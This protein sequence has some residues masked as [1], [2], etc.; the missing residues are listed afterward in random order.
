MSLQEP[1]VWFLFLPI[2]WIGGVIA[3]SIFY[4]RVH[5]KPI[6]PRIPKSVRFAQRMASGWNDENWFRRLGGAN[7][8]LMVAV[9]D[10]ELTV[11]PFFPFNLMFLPEMWGLE[12][13]VPLSRIR[14]V[15]PT[16]RFFTSAVRVELDDGRAMAL[17]LREPEAFQD[18]L[19][20]R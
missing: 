10:R 13:K 19:R 14:S 5:D 4:R 9:T 7:N 6:I 1:P 11:T 15:E 8:C 16:R 3:A 12:V 2:I 20:R 18:A 17:V